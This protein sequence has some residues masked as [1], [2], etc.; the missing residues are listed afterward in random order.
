MSHEQE[1]FRIAHQMQ[2]DGFSEDG[3]EQALAVYERRLRLIRQDKGI[4]QILAVQ[5]RAEREAWVRT[6]SRKYSLGR[7]TALA[8]LNRGDARN[9]GRALCRDTWI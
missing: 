3:I 2:A 7:I 5:Q 1:A 6:F 9:V 4:D 8:L